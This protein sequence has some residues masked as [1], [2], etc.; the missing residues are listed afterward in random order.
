MIS[1]PPPGDLT[2]QLAGY[3]A[4]IPAPAAGRLRAAFAELTASGAAPGLV[5]V[6]QP[7]AQ[8][9]AGR[10]AAAQEPRRETGRDQPAVPG[11]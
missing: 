8:G 1:T 3:A 2:R 10:P 9:P 6:L 11:P 4:Q 5:P 7:R